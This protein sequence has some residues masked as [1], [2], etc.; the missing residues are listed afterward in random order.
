MYKLYYRLETAI[1]TVQHLHTSHNGEIP[2][3]IKPKCIEI[4]VLCLLSLCF[5][6]YPPL[7]VAFTGCDMSVK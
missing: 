4:H 1:E 5:G 6:I 3:L 2:Q 7:K